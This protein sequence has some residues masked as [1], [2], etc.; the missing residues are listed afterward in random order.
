M[1]SSQLRYLLM[2]IIMAWISSAISQ[3]QKID[4]LL[5]KLETAETTQKPIIQL[6]LSKA[7]ERTDIVRSKAFAILALASSDDSIRS[8]AHNQ[9]GRAYFYENE[10]D[11]AAFRFERS[12]ALHEKL[13]YKSEAASVGISLGAVQLRKGAYKEA[14]STLIRGAAFFEKTGDSTNLAKCYSNVSTAF[15]ELGETTKAIDYGQ[16]ALRIFQKK[17]LTAF[18]AITL[19]N[20]A[21][22]FLKL[23]DTIKAKSYFLQAEEL[24]RKR[25]DKFSLAR[26][27][28]NLGNMYLETNADKSADYLL[29]ALQIKQETRNNDGIA[30]LYNNLGYLQLKKNNPKAA[31]PYLKAALDLG[32]GTNL[33]VTYNNMLDAYKALGDYQSALAYAEKKSMVNDSILKLENQ[34]GI[35][36]ISTK[37][38]T[39]KKEKEILNLQNSNLQTDMKRRQNRNL[40]LAALALLVVGCISA[41]AFIKNTRKKR[42]IAEQQ[43]ELE[44]Q[45]VEKLLKEQELVGIDAMLEG[46]EKERQRIAEDLHDSLGGKLSA[47]KLFVDE[48]KKTDQELYE[49]IRTV[50]DESYQDVRN[51]S[52]QKNASAMID[53][54]LIPAVNIVANR[55][56]ASEKLNVEV[57]NIDLKQK[58]K[59]FIEIQ[60]FR[61]I[62]ELL[63]NTIKHARA[64]QV[65]IQFS[66]DNNSL[67]VVYEDDGIGFDIQK[68]TGVGLTNIKNRIRKI[69]GSLTMDS[70]PGD[71]TTVVISV[72]I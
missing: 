33:V 38:E 17:G 9:L 46:Q 55:L 34:K 64:K 5:H 70:N 29:R 12:I 1:T 10:L 30:T 11:S 52:H 20:I 36:E 32:Q 14:I 60:L 48:V 8:E 56:K 67:N 58:I 65:N 47:L 49:K 21:G 16:K 24:A 45:K 69:Q 26:I 54:G 63:T 19:P 28:N 72:P 31:I 27:Y 15:G 50:L 7:F 53:K 61:I 66:S 44:Q 62:Q 40:L 3:E 42:I 37:Y 71:G 51:I 39:E 23:G 59:D 57:T 13:G 2:I 41:F 35:A 22:M 25:N 18:E 4:S 68:A 6:Q 43:K